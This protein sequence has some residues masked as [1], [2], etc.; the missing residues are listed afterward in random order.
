MKKRLKGKVVSNKAD[1]TIVVE[2]ERRVLHPLYKKYIKRCTRYAC[3]DFQNKA[4]K[5]D[6]VIIELTRP[7]SKTKHW[8][9]VKIVEVGSKK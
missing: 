1:K 4:K 7:L 8:R 9:L 2:V 5:G 3:H 6:K